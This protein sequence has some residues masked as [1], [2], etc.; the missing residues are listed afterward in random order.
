MNGA[1]RYG[2]A[3]C[4]LRKPHAL[5]PE[6]R[7]DVRELV[8]LR[9]HEPSR[10]Q[11]HATQLL[12]TVAAE[13]DAARVALLVKVDEPALQGFYARLGF[14]EVQRNPLVMMRVPHG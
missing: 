3:S 5:P 2:A 9:T 6:L 13:A 12:R 8:Q 7:R 10:G 1:R 11:G 4:R 14:A